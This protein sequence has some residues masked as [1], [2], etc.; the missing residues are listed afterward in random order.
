MDEHPGTADLVAI[1]RRVIV[2]EAAGLKCLSD[3]LDDSFAD[4]VRL[5][6]ALRGHLVVT[7]LGKSG[8]VA[9]KVAATLTS[10][11]TPATFMHPVEALHGDMGLVGRED[12]LL[13][14]SKSGNT[15]ELVRFILHFRNLGGAVIAVTANRKSRMAELAGLVVLMP[16]LVEA[17]PMNLAPT[18]STSMMLSL[19]D[20][21]AMALVEARG[22]KPEDFARFHPEGSLGKRLLLRAR[23][24]MH[25]GDELPVVR[26]D[27]SM[28]DLLRTIDEKALGLTCMV[29]RAGAFLGVFTDGDLRRLIRRCP[30][31]MSLSLEEAFRTSR[32]AAGDVRVKQSTI[33]PDMPIIDCRQV[34]RD[35]KIT[36]LV[37][38]D[39]QNRPI[40]V[41]RQQDIIAIGLG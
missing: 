32:R 12:A 31:P 34:M 38:V 3:S 17:C 8:L 23:D 21:L 24:L 37:V 29:D 20:A 14:F 10:T 19:G 41:V 9:R 28:E 5:V 30:N 6:E 16:D 11:G 18:T 27:Q 4:T 15:D 25:A 22:F 2:E 36:S 13:A 33:Q 26:I 35:S 39:E 1:G 40:G 7:G